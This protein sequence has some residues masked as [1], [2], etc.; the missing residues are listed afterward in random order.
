MGWLR[1][2]GTA[3]DW[4]QSE[5]KLRRAASRL[6][7]PMLAKELGSSGAWLTAEEAESFGE[8]GADGELVTGSE[9]TDVT[10]WG[11]AAAVA[12]ARKAG[13]MSSRRSLPAML[14]CQM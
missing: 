12:A 9:D 8:T 7:V 2:G 5:S 10:A 6:L 1:F 4:V 11:A 14:M 13:S 3:T